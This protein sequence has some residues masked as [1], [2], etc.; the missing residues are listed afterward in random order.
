MIQVRDT[1]Q[2]VEKEGKAG[3][4]WVVVKEDVGFWMSQWDLRAGAMGIAKWEKF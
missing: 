1:R 4:D 2:W 3:C